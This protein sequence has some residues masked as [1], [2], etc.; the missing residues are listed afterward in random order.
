MQVNGAADAEAFAELARHEG[1]VPW[2]ATSV[3]G[4]GYV[5]CK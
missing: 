4:K 1:G 5:Q 2:W 3:K